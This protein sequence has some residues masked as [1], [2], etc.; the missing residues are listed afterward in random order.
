MTSPAMP[1]YNLGKRQMAKPTTYRGLK[2]WLQST[3]F[4]HTL[5]NQSE[6]T[7]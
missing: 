7:H 2:R 6:I 3:Y 5:P 4:E 1:D